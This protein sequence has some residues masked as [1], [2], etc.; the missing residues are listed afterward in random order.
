M[1]DLTKAQVLTPTYGRLAVRFSRL[2]LNDVLAAREAIQESL[3]QGANHEPYNQE[4][5]DLIQR[6]RDQSLAQC[7][8]YN[9]APCGAEEGYQEILAGA[10]HAA[11]HR[12]CDWCRKNG[13]NDAG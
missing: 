1:V 4:S 6:I 3:R 11:K 9:T 12:G 13:G 5:D 2:A 7:G 10:G 8:F